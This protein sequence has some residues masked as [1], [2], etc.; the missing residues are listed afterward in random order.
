M[1]D[2]RTAVAH[3]TV[4]RKLRNLDEGAIEAAQAVALRRIADDARRDPRSWLSD[5]EVPKGGE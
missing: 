5:A 2:S 3:R 4:A 1:D